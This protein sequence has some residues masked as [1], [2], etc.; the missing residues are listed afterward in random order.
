[1][2]SERMIQQLETAQK[3]TTDDFY[4]KIAARRCAQQ[5]SFIVEGCIALVTGTAGFAIVGTALGAV[6]GAALPVSW[7][8]YKVWDGLEGLQDVE[9]GDWIDR[10]PEREKQRYLADKAEERKAL[11]ATK[12]TNTEAIALDGNTE[13]PQPIDPRKVAPPISQQWTEKQWQ[14]WNRI[15]QDCPDLRFALF[16]KVLV[17]SGP[18]QTGKSSLASAIAYLRAV[19]LNQ[20]CTAVSPHIDGDRIFAGDVI[21]SGGN[22]EGIE[23]W[24]TELVENFEMDSQ[25]RSLVVDELTQ[26]QGDYEK[27]GQ[28]IVRTALSESDKHGYSPILINHAKTVSAGFGNIKGCRELIDSSATKITRSYAETDYGAM[29]RSP[30]IELERP[31][32]KSIEVALPK[33]LF[34]PTLA[35]HFPLPKTEPQ[36]Q[37][38]DPF[39][40]VAFQTAAQ[41]TR[42]AIARA[43]VDRSSKPAIDLSGLPSE[44]RAIAEFAAKR[45]IPVTAREVKQCCGPIRTSDYNTDQIRGFFQQ[46]AGQNIGTVEGEG[47]RIQYVFAS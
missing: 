15:I 4:K 24:Y 22:F 2:L 20:P 13:A 29:E 43:S 16:S 26:Y 7:I 31:G 40:A 1:M 8:C 33:W 30:V 3:Q 44:L 32:K 6:A 14:L 39:G 47:D 10:L 27:L 41:Q 19:L 17:I 36:V 37:D 11:P 42:D 46:L 18:Q 21:G 34:T 25:R 12:D 9:S 23:A 5:G 28:S 38:S 35:K 45:K